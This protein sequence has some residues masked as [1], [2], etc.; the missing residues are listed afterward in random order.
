LE[1]TGKDVEKAEGDSR[2]ESECGEGA[3]A[4]FSLE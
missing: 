1:K 2:G 3:G 4:L